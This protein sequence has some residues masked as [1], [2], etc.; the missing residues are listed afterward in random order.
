M[1]GYHILLG[2]KLSEHRYA[3]P[4]RRAGRRSGRDRLPGPAWRA[5]QCAQVRRR[6]RGVVRNL[7]F[8]R[9]AVA[10]EEAKRGAAG[11]TERRAT[12]FNADKSFFGDAQLMRHIV[13][14]QP[15]FGAQRAQTAVADCNKSVS[16]RSSPLP[17]AFFDNYI[18]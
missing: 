6:L 12:F 2:K 7:V 14:R 11:P 10:E 18:V 1:L 9:L 16:V 8:Q 17:S 3:P 4:Y 15:Q 13:L 5:R